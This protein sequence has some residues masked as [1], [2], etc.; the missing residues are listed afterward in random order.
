MKLE[1]MGENRDDLKV[2]AKVFLTAATSEAL[3]D[4]L[5]HRKL[6]WWSTAYCKSY[7]QF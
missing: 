5:A 2:T 7:K 4:A 1:D 6:T 3:Q